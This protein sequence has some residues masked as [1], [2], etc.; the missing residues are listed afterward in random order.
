MKHIRL[1]IDDRSV[2]VPQ[3]ATVLEAAQQAGI[4]IPTLCHDP[5]LKPFG[6]CRLC[7]VQIGDLRGFPT[8]CTTPAQDGMVVVTDTEQI[9]QVRRTIVE[10]AIANH[11]EDCLTC[12]KSEECELLKMSRYLDV[13][14]ESLARLRRSDQILPIDTSNPAFDFDPNKCILCGK[15]VRVCDEIQGLGAID[16]TERGYQ[17]RISTFANRPWAESVCQ[18]CGECVE[19]C[20]TGALVPKNLVIP[21]K[22]V[23]TL[24]PFCGVGCTIQVGVRGGALVRARGDIDNPVNQGGLCVKGRFGLDFVNHPDRLTRPLIR[25]KGVRKS[26]YATEVGDIQE[27]FREAE[28]DEALDVVAAELINI[29]EKDGPNALGVLSSAKCTNEENYLVQKFARAVIGTNNVDHCARLCHSS[30]VVAALAAFGDGAMSNSI[31]DI[32][33]ASTILVIGS[34][35]TECH[36]I[37]GRR[38]KQNVRLNG[39]K[40][41]VADP[42]ATELTRDAVLHLNHRPGTD[43]ALLNG[44]MLEIVAKSWHDKKFIADRCENF[45]AFSASL[46]PYTPEYVE[47]ITGV[48]ASNIRKAAEILGRSPAAV[49]IYGMGITQ[50][51][52]GTDNVKS[53][54]NL[55]MLTGNMGRKGTGFSPLRGQNNVQ[56]ACDMGA[57]PNVYPGYQKVIDPVAQAKFSQAWKVALDDQIGLSLT[58]MVRAAD[59]GQLLGMYI[60]GE[61]PLM[62]EPDL[63]HARQT[64]KNLKFLA[65]QDIFLTETALMADVILPTASFAEKD[66]TFTNTERR[67]QMLR[68]VL[69][70]PGDAR[71]DWQIISDIAS[72]MGYPMA[73]GSSRDIMAE[74]A[75]VAPIYG[76][77]SHDRLLKRAGGLQWPCWDSKHPGTTR[78]H[79]KQFTRGKGRFHVVEYQPPAEAPTEEFPMVLTTGRVLEHFHT[80]SMSRRSQVLET[81]EPESHLDISPEDSDSMGLDEGD[82]VLVRSRRGEIVTKVHADRRI[83][84]GMAFMA[85]HWKEAP[86]NVLTNPAIDPVSKIP[87]FK[88]ASVKTERISDGPDVNEKPSKL[89]SIT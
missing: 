74:I 13:Q 55:L 64:F 44:I 4:Y 43:V 23:K 27:V 8:A 83:Q 72:R 16:F 9:A 1:T 59:Q 62:S 80:G 85:F 88:V 87:E 34:N 31:T 53:I 65:V 82:T 78:L 75:S 37:I 12:H 33:Q 81:L 36:P 28:W 79:V 42:R 19:R 69:A 22:E 25:K 47:G 10:M 38:I 58:D 67:V 56:G 45:E 71:Q 20:P 61:N 77:I 29:R 35:T 68:Q 54:A 15:C 84:N 3:G 86:A 2:K 7:I 60:M 24:C 5:H 57:L 50:H 6:A 89:R 39:A 11:P 63:D 17:T 18:T 14:K 52:T 48:S 70:P 76:G 46:E 40:L 30:T 73:Y 51:T 21:Q 26:I 49:V 41:I 32:A 66:G